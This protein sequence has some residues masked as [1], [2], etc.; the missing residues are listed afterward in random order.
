MLF[1][2]RSV[3]SAYALSKPE[4]VYANV[5]WSEC[6]P[7][8][9]MRTKTVH[10]KQQQ[11]GTAAAATAAAAAAAAAAAVEMTTA[12]PLTTTTSAASAATDQEMCPKSRIL[13]KDCT[14]EELSEGFLHTNQKISN[15]IPLENIQAA[16]SCWPRTSDCARR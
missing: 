3:H 13:T 9:L 8:S 5:A 12:L 4:C 7:I 10:I 16:K 15:A 6:D 11:Q 14:K 1:P 2:H